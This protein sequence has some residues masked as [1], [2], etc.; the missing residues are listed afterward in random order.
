MLWFLLKRLDP[1]FKEQFIA[2]I[3][4]GKGKPDL[5]KKYFF[6]FYHAELLHFVETTIQIL[7]QSFLIYLRNADWKLNNKKG[8]KENFEAFNL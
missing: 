8:F 5:K 3:T 6:L 4:E 7:T 2:L 1:L